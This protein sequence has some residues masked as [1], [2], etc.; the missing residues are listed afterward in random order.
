MTKELP[1]LQRQSLPEQ[2]AREIG[3]RILRNDFQPGETLATEPELSLQLQVS[4]P[5]LREALKMLGSK[6][7]I[8]A[9]PKTGTR[10]RPRVEWNLFDPDVIAWQSENAPDLAFLLKICEVRG[11]FEP[12]TAG[13]AALRATNDELTRIAQACLVMGQAVNTIEEYISTDLQ[14][15]MAICTA[16]HN[17]LL[18]TILTTLETPLRASRLITSQMPGA[19]ERSLPA[20]QEV[21]EAIQRRDSQA[22]EEAMREIL[23]I[24][25]EDIRRTFA[26]QR[27]S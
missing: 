17:E 23:H 15:H 14:F 6:R 27:E 9:R 20:H 12:M 13:L 4:R 22:A 21:N 26:E 10:V 7:L 24:V 8:E 3:L 19:N 16:A 2:I 5:V 11:M 18:S 25:T 1:S